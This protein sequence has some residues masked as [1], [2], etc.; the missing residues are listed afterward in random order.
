MV[1]VVAPAYGVHIVPAAMRGPVAADIAAALVAVVAVVSLS[2]G[3]TKSEC[4]DS[5]QN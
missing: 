4:G 1:P 5:R 2:S 3:R